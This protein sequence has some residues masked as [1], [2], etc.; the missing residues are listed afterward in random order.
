[1]YAASR[2]PQS[3]L[4]AQEFLLI[5]VKTIT[6]PIKTIIIT[7][8]KGQGK[9]SCAIILDED[10]GVDPV[11]SSLRSRREWLPARTRE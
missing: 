11:D 8:A 7:A 4:S 6:N 1:M 3:K 2:S 5:P 10:W 9:Y